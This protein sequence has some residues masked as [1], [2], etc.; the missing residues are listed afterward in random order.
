MKHLDKIF[1]KLTKFHINLA[2]IKSYI[3][4]FD[5]KLLEQ[6]IDNLDISTSEAKLKV[7]SSFKFS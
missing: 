5:V 3:D 1:D 6:Q 7:L 2:F 4:F